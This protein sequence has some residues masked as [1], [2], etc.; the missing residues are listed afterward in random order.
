MGE[1]GVEATERRNRA[2]VRDRTDRRLLPARDRPGRRRNIGERDE[3]VDPGRARTQETVIARDR[4]SQ[5]GSAPRCDGSRAAA[6]RDRSSSGPAAP[7]GA[8]QGPRRA[9]PKR[10]PPA[11]GR[12]RR[13]T[14]S[15][16]HGRTCPRHEEADRT[17]VGVF[18]DRE[19]GYHDHGDGGFGRCRSRRCHD[20]T[21]TER[22]DDGRQGAD[23][24]RASAR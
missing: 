1:S 7:P 24:E 14:L 5:R 10:R 22:C 13:G 18:R 17:A 3:A 4:R 23:Q 8:G 11:R 19:G 21:R 20:P 15:A 6:A 9:R 2:R 16:G 12:A